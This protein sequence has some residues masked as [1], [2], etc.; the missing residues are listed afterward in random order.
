[1]P[2]HEETAAL[3]AMEERRRRRARSMRRRHWRTEHEEADAWG[4]AA[5][6]AQVRRRCTGPW[7]KQGRAECGLGLDEIQRLLFVCTNLKH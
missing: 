1:M 3:A 2:Y 7:G 5:L 6:A 4:G